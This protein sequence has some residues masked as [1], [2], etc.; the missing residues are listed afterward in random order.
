MPNQTSKIENAT[1]VHEPQHESQG[2]PTTV[3]SSLE[4]TKPSEESEHFVGLCTDPRV[5]GIKEKD[6][7]RDNSPF[8]K[9][10]H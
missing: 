3:Q 6:Q 4:R 9:C 7:N 8:H 10:A 5:M 1:S 2:K